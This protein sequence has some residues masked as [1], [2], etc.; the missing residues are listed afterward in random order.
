MV[1]IRVEVAGDADEVVRVMSHLGGATVG[2]PDGEQL[3]AMGQDRSETNP[4]SEPSAVEISPIATVGRL[5]GGV[6]RRLH[7]EPGRRGQAYGALRVAGRYRG[8][9]PTCTLPTGRPDAGGAALVA[10]ADGPRA[11]EV[12]ARAGDDAFP[13]GGG[14]QP[15]AELLRRSRLRV[16]GGVLDVRREG[17]GPAGRGLGVPLMDPRRWPLGRTNCASV[18]ERAAANCRPVD[19]AGLRGGR[20]RQDGGRYVRC[21]VDANTALHRLNVPSASGDCCVERRGG[22]GTVAW[23]TGAGRGHDGEDQGRLRSLL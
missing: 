7:G 19:P 5:D 2:V 18:V 9:P 23:P 13:A 16:D 8:H 14:Q 17:S 21:M 15:A 4:L 12:P 6:G 22:G 20:R 11:A 3:P 1:W 10:D